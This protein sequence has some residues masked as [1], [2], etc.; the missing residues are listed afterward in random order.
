MTFKESRFL[1]RFDEFAPKAFLIALAKFEGIFSSDLIHQVNQVGDALIGNELEQT[2]Q[3][4]CIAQKDV[5][6]YE[7][8]KQ[9]YEDLLEVDSENASYFDK[10]DICLRRTGDD[11]ERFLTTPLSDANPQ[12]AVKRLFGGADNLVERVYQ[13]R[14]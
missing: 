6:F 1:L 4:I 12:T 7:V 2:S 13:L 5:I 11:I 10:S 3:L 14:F 9:A 8:F